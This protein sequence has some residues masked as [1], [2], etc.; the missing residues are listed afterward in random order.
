[1]LGVSLTW[2]CRDIVMTSTTI[3]G[4]QI[5]RIEAQT[6]IHAREAMRLLTKMQKIHIRKKTTRAGPLLGL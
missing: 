4:T 6:L 1:M 2:Y 5:N 3:S